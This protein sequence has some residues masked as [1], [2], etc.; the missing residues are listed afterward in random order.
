MPLQAKLL[1]IDRWTDLNEYEGSLS[2]QPLEADTAP[3]TCY[4]MLNAGEWDTLKVGDTLEGEL[5]LLALADAEA[6]EAPPQFEQ[7]DGVNYAVTGRLESLDGEM[8][9]LDVAGLTVNADLDGHDGEVEEGEW[10]RVAGQL[11]L[12]LQ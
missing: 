8:L 10:V 4:V 12:E 5:T 11:G 7:E 6:G 9:V 3:L 2:L 1:K